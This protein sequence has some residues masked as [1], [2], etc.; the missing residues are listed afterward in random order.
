MFYK[1]VC[2]LL[3]T[4]VL[5][6]SAR[7]E[8]LNTLRESRPLVV[9][10]YWQMQTEKLTIAEI[11]YQDLTH[12]IYNA[13]QAITENSTF[14]PG[15]T[16]DDDLAELVATAHKNGVKVLAILGEGPEGNEDGWFTRLLV[17]KEQRAKFISG[18]VDYVI[19]HNL[20]GIDYDNEG[21]IKGSPNPTLYTALIK[22][23]RG[24]FD[25][26][27]P[28]LI[29]SL[30]GAAWPPCFVT[31]DAYEHLDF[32]NV[33]SYESM[34]HAI[35]ALDLWIEY[36]APKEKLIMGMAVGFSDYG[37]DTKLAA[38][39]V[40]YVVDNGYGGVMLFQLNYDVKGKDSMLKAVGDKVSQIKKA[41]NLTQSSVSEKWKNA[42]KPK[43]VK[44]KDLTLADNGK[45]SYS[46]V[47][48]PDATTMDEKAAAELQ[49]WLREMTGA[50][51]PIVADGEPIKDK[52]RIISIGQTM[53]LK[54]AQLPAA[55]ED[56]DDE[57]YGIGVKGE[58][59]YLWGGRT[60][61]VINSVFALLEEDLGCRWYTDEHVMIPKRKTLIFGP[62]VR[63]YKPAL[64]LRDPLWLAARDADWSLRNRTNAPWAKVPEEWGGRVDYDGMFV[65]TFHKLLPP[66]E[67]FDEHPEYYEV[68]SSGNRNT[69]QLCTTNPDVV[70]LVKEKVRAVL[71]ESPHTEIIS[72]SKTDG[73]GH[74]CHCE[75]C[76]PMDDAEESH[77][78]SI[79]YLV[80]A[81]AEDIEKDYP[82][83]TISTLAYGETLPVPKTMRP[84]NNVCI[85]LC[86]DEVGSWLRP[87]APARICDFAPL[88]EAWSAVHDRM[89]IWDYNVNFSHYLAPMPNMQVTADN[90]QF[91][92]ENNAEG[93]MP[94]ANYQSS[95]NERE[96]LRCW[97]SAKLLWDPSSDVFELMDDFIWGHYGKAA[98]AVAEYNKL[99]YDQGQKYKEELSG[100]YLA[101]LGYDGIRY[102]IDHPFLSKEFLAKATELYDRAEGLA[103]NEQVLHR[104]Q[105]DRLAIM[106]VKL[107]RGPEFVG[108]E[109][110][111]VL[112]RFE[113]IARRIGLT[114][115]REGGRDLDEKLEGWKDQWVDWLAKDVWLNSL[116][117]KG[118]G[119]PLSIT[120]NGKS[121]YSIVISPKATTQDEKAAAELQLWLEE[122]T[123]AELPIVKGLKGA[124]DKFK[125]I[126]I[127]KTKLF[128]RAGIKAAN[129]DLADEGYGIAVKEN[130]LYLWGGRTRGVINAAFALLEEDL[131]C[132]W[133]TDEAIMIPKNPTLKFAPVSRTYKPA[134]KLRDPYYMVAFNGTWS[135]RNR[136]NAPGAKVPEEWGGYMEYCG[137]DSTDHSSMFVHTFHDLLPPDEYYEDHPEYFMLVADG[138]RNTHQLCTTHPDVVKIV[139]ES[140]KRYLKANPN[141]RIIS[142][143]KMDGSKL[144]CICPNCKALDDAE[145]TN[146]AALLYLV[147]SVAEAIETDYPHVTVST[148]AYLE[149]G[150]PPK[151]MRPRKNVAIRL[152]SDDVG[153]WLRPFEPSEICQF[154]K[155][156]KDWST[157]H[158]K[159]HIWHYT[160]NFSHYLAPMPNMENIAVDI[161][162]LVENHAESIMTQGGFQSVC[163]RDW[164]RSWV[165]AKLM[166]EPYLDLDKLMHDF[167][168]GY[169]GKA[170][171]AIAKYNALLRK[172]LHD[173]RAIM[174]V[175]HLAG[176]DESIRYPM[177]HPFLSKE[178][179]EKSTKL[180]DH[181][182]KL[183]E[184]ER[185]L[186]RVQRDRLPIMYV[187][188]MRGPELVGDGYGELI[189]RFEKIAREIGVTR[190]REGTPDLDEKLKMWRDQWLSCEK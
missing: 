160:V 111:D 79:L 127:G 5:A 75:S 64:K 144:S 80:N 126:S 33:M 107:M 150:K 148:L 9:G 177:D 184:N 113:K 90:I 186:K 37:R 190:L 29:I 117:P 157:V 11:R 82:Q 151:T 12:I 34:K 128:E 72:V 101:K 63:T 124:K 93:V 132:R 52:S 10:Y 88:L 110:G 153:A 97:V 23:T 85:R 16:N 44:G 28:N 95:G 41:R 62:V 176:P 48:G 81:V 84:R 185:V 175:P 50:K 105:M 114:H 54:A 180:Y 6:L 2:A 31:P 125:V 94:Q 35:D 71:K 67:Y 106:Y 39:E 166:W 74:W 147:N 21:P 108:Q 173:N 89:Y 163:E 120:E 164:L 131:G 32:I 187:K 154:G 145:G 49:K 109:Y 51:L 58:N 91:F 169:F 46:I 30:A 130:Q 116:K 96:W 118:N 13:E 78:A 142:V 70:R 61:G 3:L 159:M 27:N 69:H 47:T 59:L 115:L 189:E 168:Y 99:L 42:L 22:E 155:L 174:T 121:D 56:L 55:N 19:K 137:G 83:V 66:G 98:P 161:R 134:L 4:T 57:G 122:M 87:F 167:I 92:V 26:V 139:I 20:D 136:T 1:C 178:F 8:K 73:Q 183:A 149:T 188:L 181:A 182:E 38:D 171:P 179:L 172:Q 40:R 152:C 104:V 18:I 141:A 112:N 24:A 100:P 158:D 165:I 45:S 65:H 36:K 102:G 14:S 119:S 170:A 146:M 43:G 123:G 162:F 133:Y 15:Q 129:E 103:E 135:L 143:S 156:V 68:D 86:N 138:S 17:T 60:R 53:A 7:G 77:M 76:K 140:T 25:R